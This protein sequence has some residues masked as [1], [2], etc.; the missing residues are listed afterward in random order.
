ML[1]S[2]E[3]VK[4]AYDKLQQSLNNMLVTYQ[5]TSIVESNIM[6]VFPYQS[7]E[8]EEAIPSNLTPLSEIE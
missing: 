1:V 6:E 7:D 5:I 2:A 3:N 4:D 8:K